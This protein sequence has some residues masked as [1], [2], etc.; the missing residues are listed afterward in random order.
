MKMK[1]ALSLFT[2]FL[3]F[4]AGFAQADTPADTAKPATAPAPGATGANVKQAKDGEMEANIVGSRKEKLTVGKFDPPAAFNLEDI[5]NFPEDRLQ[6]VLNNSLIF[7]EGRDFSTMMDFQDEQ[8]FHPWLAELSQAPFLTMKSAIEKSPKDW[9]FTVIDQAGATVS[10]QEGKGTPPAVI[11]WAGDDSVR[12]H[13]AVETVYIPQLA[14]T[15][16]QG[17]HHT[18][19]GQP[20]QFSSLIYKDHSKMVVELSSKRLFKDKKT[21]LSNEAPVILD[22]VCDLIREE[23]HMMFAIQ[24]YDSETDMARGRQQTLI[25]YFIDNLNL[26]AKQ[27]IA[28]DPLGAEKRGAAM[29]ITFNGTPGGAE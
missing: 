14:T 5:Q 15:D 18:Y 17:Y 27:I 26:S 11:S 28:A 12:D 4:A 7:E 29:A 25:Q 9:T 21:E 10:K 2:L 24:P 6:P 1:K 20:V 13:V 3:V 23:G 8:L 22:K 16:N 19:M